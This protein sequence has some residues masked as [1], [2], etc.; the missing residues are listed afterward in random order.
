MIVRR[1]TVASALAAALLLAAARTSYGQSS[2]A[3]PGGEVTGDTIVL[4]QTA[5][6]SGPNAPTGEAKWGLQAYLDYTNAHGGVAGKKLRLI[7]YDDGYQPSQTTSLVKKLVYDDRVFA[8]VGSVG[9]PTNGAVYQTLDESG[10]PLVGMASGGPIFYHPTRKFVFPAWPLYT[11]DGKT[12]GDFVKRHFSHDSVA[13][14]YQDD[15]FGKPILDGITSEL[16]KAPDMT[17]PYVPSQVDFS[18]DV[19][20]LKS[21]GI[22]VVLFATI[23]TPAAQILNQMA[24]LNYRPTRILTSSSCGYSGI[25]KTIASLEGTYCTA[26]LPA[27]GSDDPR[28]AVFSK[29]M[30]Q[31]APGHPAEVYA[32]WGWLSGE[33]TVAALRAIKGPI[34]REKFVAA[35]NG[36]HNFETIGGRL[37][38]SADSH[39]G[40]CC[41]FMWQAK[42]DRWVVEP[43]KPFDGLTSK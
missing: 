22:K 4:G 16:G 2:E 31:Y 23:V 18:S 11:T 14:I 13:V 26:F 15:A 35:L 40:I 39:D 30:Q 33:V 25:F 5:A 9:T 17:L 21:A 1:L 37:S 8:V 7:S 43:D 36:L 32:G 12:M 27:P 28:L 20:K 19:I 24:N 34:T 41:Q 38:Y 10:V 29:A 3:A 42:G 6:Q